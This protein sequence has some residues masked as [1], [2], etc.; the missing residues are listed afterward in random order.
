[1]LG[2]LLMDI[3]REFKGAGNIGEVYSNKRSD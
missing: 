1:M 3:R 2:V